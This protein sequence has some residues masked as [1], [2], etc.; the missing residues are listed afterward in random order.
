M[1][2]DDDEG[3]PFF[4]ADGALVTPG[5]ETPTAEGAEALAVRAGFAPAPTHGDEAPEGWNRVTFT[6]DGRERIALKCTDGSG[7]WSL[8]GSLLRWP[9]LLRAAGGEVTDAT[10]RSTP[11]PTLADDVAALRTEVKSYWYEG[12]MPNH[13][14]ALFDRI[15]G[16]VPQRATATPDGRPLWQH[17]CGR[18]ASGP[19]CTGPACRSCGE[20]GGWRA[21]YV[22]P[23]GV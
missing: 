1:F 14:A 19:G 16:A 18:I 17:G 5:V 23:G 4:G 13:M 7:R 9:S 2:A 11:V 21:L 6:R 10:E 22:M 3:M 20:I 15:V 12:Q 8:G